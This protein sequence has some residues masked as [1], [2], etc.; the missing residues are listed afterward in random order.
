MRIPALRSFKTEDLI[1]DVRSRCLEKDT[2]IYKLQ[3]AGRKMVKAYDDAEEIGL[4]A[5]HGN[6]EANLTKCPGC[7]CDVA[8][9]E[10]R[11]ACES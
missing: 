4:L 10:L 11:K 6:H 8:I 9:E 3:A 5:D 1:E 7:A 2:L